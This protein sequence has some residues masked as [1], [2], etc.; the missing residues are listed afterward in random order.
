MMMMMRRSRNTVNTWSIWH[1][2]TTYINDSLWHGDECIKFWG[3]KVEVQ[4]HGG[5]TY[6]GTITAQVEAYSTRCLVSSFAHD[7]MEHSV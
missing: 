2:F 6:A 3:Q 7:K 5:I 4:G 1:I